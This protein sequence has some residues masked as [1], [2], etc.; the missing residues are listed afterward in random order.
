MQADLLTSSDKQSYFINCKVKGDLLVVGAV[1]IAASTSSPLNLVSAEGA[2]LAVEI[3]ND[4]VNKPDGV[5]AADT[6]FFIVS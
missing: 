6:S 2:N 3:P 5:V 1:Y 4:A